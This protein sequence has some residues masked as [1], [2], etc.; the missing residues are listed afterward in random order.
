METLR[1]EIRARLGPLCEHM[2]ETDFEEL[3]TKVAKNHVKPTGNSW[4]SR[5]GIRENKRPGQG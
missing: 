2:D 4:P 5:A 3:V 1:G